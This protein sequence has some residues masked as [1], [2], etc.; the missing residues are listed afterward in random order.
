MKWM[1]KRSM[2]TFE[3]LEGRA[4][5][6]SSRWSQLV[7]SY[8]LPFGLCVILS[9]LLIYVIWTRPCSEHQYK[10]LKQTLKNVEKQ[11]KQLEYAQKQLEKES[12]YWTKSANKYR[13]SISATDSETAD[14]N[15][16]IQQLKRNHEVC[17]YLVFLRTDLSL[18]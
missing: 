2:Y 12:E 10:L 18:Q 5:Y 15:K 7:N 14:V 16:Q 1:T 17:G 8:R 4:D 13:K 9:I 3:R 6:R 11:Y